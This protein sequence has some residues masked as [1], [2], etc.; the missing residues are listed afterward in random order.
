M[1]GCESWTVKKAEHWRIDAF[2]LWCW[3]RLL[4]VP[5]TARRSN[6]SILKDGLQGDQSWVFIGRN[7]AKAK[8]PILWPPH[9]KS[10]L[11]GKDSDAGR[12]WGQEEE[13]TTRM[14]WLAGI[15]NLMDMSLGKLW[16]LVMDREA[17]CAA[18]HGVAKSWTRLSDW[19]N[20]TDGWFMLRFDRKQE[21][22]VKQLSFNKKLIINIMNLT[23]VA[24]WMILKFI[25]E[26]H[27]LI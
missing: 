7:D 17:C 16:E 10:W 20:W 23:S 18:V 15:N 19:T 22:S 3:R 11:V 27:M 4:R 5:S 21:N 24:T 25:W 13:G 26:S 14:K 8:I 9:V 12:D 6:Q 2:E 1:D